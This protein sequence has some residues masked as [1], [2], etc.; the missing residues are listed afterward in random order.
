MLYSIV[1]AELVFGQADLPRS[2]DFGVRNIPVDGGILEVSGAGD[3]MRVQRL[4]STNPR[5]YLN[6]AYAPGSPYPAPR[7]EH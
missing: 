6:P 2:G 1:P 4:V 5:A 7:Q 3:S